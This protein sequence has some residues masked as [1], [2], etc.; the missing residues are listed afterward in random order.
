MDLSD[1][2]LDRY[3]RHIVLPQLGGAVA[4]LF[5]EADFDSRPRYTDPE[6]LRTNLA[7]VILQMA[8]LDLG[9]LE[10]PVRFPFLDPPDARSIR[11]GRQD[12]PFAKL[13]WPAMRSSAS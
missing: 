5:A 4:E 1:E 11:D 10:G 12:T 2:E 9:A 8:A 13:C 6:L 7:A 3:A